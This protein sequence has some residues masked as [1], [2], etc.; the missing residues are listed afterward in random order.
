M[1]YRHSATFDHP[2]E[3]V[4]EWHTRPG[5]LA[6]LMPPWQPVRP[7]REATSLRDGE[8]A[9][10]LPCGLTWLARHDPAGY[11]EGRRFTDFLATPVLAQLAPWR[12][13]HDFTPLPDGRA[14][15]TDTVETRLPARLLSQMFAYRERQ[16]RYD[17]DAHRR[18]HPEDG[19]ALTVAVTGSSGLVGRA[20]T[21]LLTSGG[22]RVARLVRPGRPGRQPA[23]GPHRL[24][25]PERPAPDL[26]EGVD[27]VVHLAGQPIAG[28]FTPAHKQAVRSSRVGPTRQLAELAAKSGV[29]TFV[30][31]SA[32][33]FYGPDRGDEPLTEDSPRG[34]GFLAEVVADWE[35]AAQHAAANGA[36]V[37]TVR[38]GIVQSPQ[39]GVLRLQRLLFM[40]G[41]GG[42]L[43]GGD[44]WVP[45]VGIDDLAD[46]YLS[47]LV[48]PG[49]Q[50]PVNATAPEPARNA[51]LTRVLAR[52]L[53]RPA[54]LAV[55][56]WAPRLLLGPEGATELALA[57][58][59]VLPAKLLAA[60]HR[61]RY[62]DLEGA[63]RHVLGRAGLG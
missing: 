4:F 19:R 50:G 21:A 41:L 54:A 61:F 8:A 40:A 5:A 48:S 26:L 13:T 10:A 3:E 32:V 60:G 47:A 42:P 17:L 11:E 51:E 33:G 12:H 63:L 46:I 23:S 29:R 20:V 7:L 37:V 2:V 58:Q 1:P 39:G 59:K 25:Q 52:V 6:R 44:A 28:P 49:L 22:H 55:P 36:R 34:R 38:T 45:W 35:E 16:L 18:W 27:A 15:V 14:Q 62:P 9:L 53:R 31:A 57:S 30:S 24:W 56:A 43:A